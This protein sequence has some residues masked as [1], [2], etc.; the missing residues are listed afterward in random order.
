[1]KN[2]EDFEKHQKQV[3]DAAKMLKL[4][5]RDQIRA[6]LK[7]L[8]QS[9]P[10]ASHNLELNGGPQSDLESLKENYPFAGSEAGM[11]SSDEKLDL[12]KVHITDEQWRG[13]VRREKLQ[14]YE[15][16]LKARLRQCM[17][18]QVEALIQGKRQTEGTLHSLKRQVDALD[19]LVSS[20]SA[21]SPSPS[22]TSSGFA[23]LLH[24]ELN[25][26]KNQLARS[27]SKPAAGISSQI[28]IVTQYN[29]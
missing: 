7:D 26:T 8:S 10:E 1:M 28:P 20:T 3:K 6:G 11:R 19:E 2:Q 24:E 18:K 16:R 21:D 5:V 12:T 23:D 15:D 22:F 17:S 29:M 14:H 4:E 9:P 25:L 13:K 27:P